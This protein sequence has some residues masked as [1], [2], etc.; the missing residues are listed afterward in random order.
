MQSVIHSKVHQVTCKPS[1]WL[2]TNVEKRGVHMFEI[3]GYFHVYASH[4]RM[5]YLKNLGY[6][7]PVLRCW[8]CVVYRAG[9][10]AQSRVSIFILVA[11]K[12]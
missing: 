9:S 5:E 12:W 2:Q 8:M 1:S 7:D 11:E 6:H 4:L 3:L 10:A